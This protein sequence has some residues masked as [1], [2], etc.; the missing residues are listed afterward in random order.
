MKLSKISHGCDANEIALSS[1]LYGTDR[2]GTHDTD[3]RELMFLTDNAGTFFYSSAAQTRTGSKLPRG[4]LRARAIRSR[5][6]NMGSQKR[7]CFAWWSCAACWLAYNGSGAFHEPARRILLYCAAQYGL[8][9]RNTY[10]P[11]TP[12][13]R[14]VFAPAR[15]LRDLQRHR[16]CHR[17]SQCGRVFVYYAPQ[18]ALPD[19]LKA[20]S[21]MF[22][23]QHCAHLDMVCYERA[24]HRLAVDVPPIHPA[25]KVR[26]GREGWRQ[27]AES[28]QK[29]GNPAKCLEPAVLR[30]SM[31]EMKR[32]EPDM[33]M[34]TVTPCRA[35]AMRVRGSG[36][37]A[38]G[39][40]GVCG[41][42]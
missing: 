26:H 12:A 33:T 30:P 8:Y 6:Q 16:R 22:D 23:L 13:A 24:Q 41:V 25:R 20:Q 39:W 4:R 38:H 36:L 28:S 15:Q 19:W 17:A 34:A 42:G 3:S 2:T 35:A 11:R 14:T 27:V 1:Q 32:M 29:T 31:H 5:R 37:R 7:S 18:L 40:N 9:Q 10:P 21:T